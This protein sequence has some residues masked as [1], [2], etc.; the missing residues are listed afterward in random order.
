MSCLE[1]QELLSAYI[2]GELEEKQQILV[3]DHLKEC[4]EC[5]KVYDE[6][7]AISNL[8]SDVAMEEP[9]DDLVANIMSEIEKVE[10]SQKVVK[11]ERQKT[12]PSF[13]WQWR[14]I[15]AG[16]A[17]FFISLSVGILPLVTHNLA[18]DSPLE[19]LQN[20]SQDEVARDEEPLVKTQDVDASQAEESTP[21]QEVGIMSYQVQNEESGESEE[22]PESFKSRSIVATDS[23]S[24]DGEDQGLVGVI[25]ITNL[26]FAI[27]G[28]VLGILLIWFA[29]PNKQ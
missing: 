16:L 26:L 2:D 7:L 29:K 5:Q 1:I 22:S 27:S 17:I 8:F 3:S 28:S 24:L 23:Q 12:R 20:E 10:K 21:D 6:L 13:G 18:L 9:P 4:K 14:K 19:L 15:A 25:G 11:L